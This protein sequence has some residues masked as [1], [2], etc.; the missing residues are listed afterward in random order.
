M[1][2]SEPV[3]DAWTLGKKG[4]RSRVMSII[5]RLYTLRSTKKYHY[6]LSP[7]QAT[8]VQCSEMKFQWI[9]FLMFL[10]QDLWTDLLQPEQDHSF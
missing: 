2:H 4:G 3:T 8:A 9:K 7:A 10:I 6:P 1:Y 5:R